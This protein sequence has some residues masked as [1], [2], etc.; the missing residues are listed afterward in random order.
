LA[1]HDAFERAMV[2]A[3]AEA[4]SAGVSQKYVI[5]RR[6]WLSHNDIRGYIGRAT[7][8][9]SFNYMPNWPQRAA[10]DCVLKDV[11]AMRDVDE[12]RAESL[13]RSARTFLRRWSKEIVS[14]PPPDRLE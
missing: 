6:G 13:L 4:L 14:E 9:S 1:V 5:E 3:V 8:P 10:L 11:E 7:R 12:V 2:D